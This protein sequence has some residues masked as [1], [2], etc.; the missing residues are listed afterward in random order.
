MTRQETRIL[1]IDDDEVILFAIADILE[2]AGYKVHTLASPIGATSVIVREAIDLAVIDVNL[3]VMQGDSVVRLLASWERVKDL[4]VVIISGAMPALSTPLRD[5]RFVH[6][7]QLQTHLLGAIEAELAKGR[8]RSTSMGPASGM[9]AHELVTR[10]TAHLAERL[11]DAQAQF[12]AVVAGDQVQRGNLLQTL[13]FV[14]GQAQLL[15]LTDIA[16]VLG[17]LALL[18]EAAHAAKDCPPSVYEAFDDAVASLTAS[19]PDRDR[20]MRAL[21]QALT[22]LRG[23]TA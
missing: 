20:R 17:G 11:S 9:R 13:S 16:Q 2:E 18:V 8:T 19:S 22:R 5:V 12:R 10:F 3:P 21:S 6:K 7:G 15:A 23:A 14:R 1:V 4:P